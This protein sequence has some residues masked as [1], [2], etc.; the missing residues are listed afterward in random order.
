MGF[1][2]AWNSIS[3]VLT[4]QEQPDTDRDR[5]AGPQQAA[6][7]RPEAPTLTPVATRALP[8]KVEPRLATRMAAMVGKIAIDGD[9]DGNTIEAGENI[10]LTGTI[11]GK[12]NVIRIAG[13]RNAQ[14]LNLHIFGNRNEVLVGA[15]SLLQKLRVEIGSKRWPC[16]QARLKIGSG[17]SIAS[18]GRFI[19]PNSGNV[20][21]I[22]ENC[23]FSSNIVV[24]GGEYPHLIFDKESGEY[25]DVSDGIF[26]GNHVWVG[27][28]AFIGKSVTLADDSIVGTRSVVTKRFDE[29]HCVI[30]GNPA[31][32]VKRDVQWVANEYML[33]DQ[34]PLGHA[35]F[36]ETRTDRINRS[37]RER[38]AL[39]TACEDSIPPDPVEPD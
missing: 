5:D 2:S 13:T 28:G 29:Q 25:L 3:A 7:S 31:R 4:G 33:E 14:T 38:A 1:R 15:G 37:E 39:D 21:E 20:L 12:G 24:R 16:S 22:G 19:L 11:K 10:T 35:M 8:P 34:F 26:I 27:E 30:A 9:I 23:M 18:H 17:F 32:I 36:A 6:K